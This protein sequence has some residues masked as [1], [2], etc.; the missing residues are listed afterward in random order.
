MDT[1]DKLVYCIKHNK[2]LD[3]QDIL[4]DILDKLQK[5][6]L[7]PSTNS[8]DWCGKATSKKS[9]RQF[10]HYL[11]SDGKTLYATDA[12]RMH[13]CDTDLELGWYCPK[14]KL[15][16]NK[17]ITP[18][19]YNKIVPGDDYKIVTNVEVIQ[20][21]KRKTKYRLIKVGDFY[22]REKFFLDATSF[23]CDYELRQYD[24]KI[25]VAYSNG[26]NACLMCVNEKGI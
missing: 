13:W 7:K 3:D 14:T 16:I 26:L 22:Y 15:K 10:C 12:Y 5:T 25:V 19:L 9:I 17:D 20:N 18:P 23:K 24:Y 6:K 8:V 2:P 21:T 1:I 4:L 11:Y